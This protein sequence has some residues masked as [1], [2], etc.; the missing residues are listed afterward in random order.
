MYKLQVGIIHFVVTFLITSILFLGCNRERSTPS[1]YKY[2]SIVEDS[3]YQKDVQAFTMMIDTLITKKEGPFYAIRFENTQNISIDTILYS[4][5]FLRSV[6][7]VITQNSNQSVPLSEN[8][9]GHHYNARAFLGQ[10]DSEY[11]SWSIRWFSIINLNYYSSYDDISD[12]MKERYFLDLKTLKN[13]DGESRYK[14]NVNDIRFWNG[15]V[16][17]EEV[18]MLEHHISGDGG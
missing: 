6:F 12:K 4:E 15:P 13:S 14:Y 17:D 5:D 10:R 9:A 1:D 18:Q 8:P 7:F 16:W 3:L 2:Q 11:S